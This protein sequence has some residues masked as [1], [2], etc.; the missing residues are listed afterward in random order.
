M[1]GGG[2]EP[3]GEEE[4]EEE[5]EEE[6]V[7]IEEVCSLVSALCGVNPKQQRGGEVVHEAHL[8]CHVGPCGAGLLC[9]PLGRSVRGPGSKAPTIPF[10]KAHTRSRSQAIDAIWSKRDSLYIVL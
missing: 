6:G 3:P 5:K 8:P 2:D 4:E 9:V 10:Y 1:A 7:D